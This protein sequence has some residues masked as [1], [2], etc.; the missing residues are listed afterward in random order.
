MNQISWKLKLESKEN[1]I[2]L[3]AS[4]STPQGEIR[5]IFSKIQI[6]LAL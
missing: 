2:I 4:F 5:S 3:E 1:I 6:F